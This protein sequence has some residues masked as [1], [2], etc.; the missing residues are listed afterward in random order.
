MRSVNMFIVVTMKYME[1]AGLVAIGALCTFEAARFLTLSGDFRKIAGSVC[2][3]PLPDDG[4]ECMP[5]GA[6]EL[7]IG[8]ALLWY[9]ILHVN[10]FVNLRLALY[11]TCL[12]IPPC[13]LCWKPFNCLIC[14]FG[15]P[16]KGWGAQRVC[17]D[18]CLTP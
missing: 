18:R 12:R 17:T 9:H 6:A 8:L 2:E 5:G 14:K 4:P 10:L 1:L 13:V 3:E 15:P 16:D 11:R 7:I